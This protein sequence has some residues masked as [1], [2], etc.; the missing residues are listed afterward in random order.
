[1]AENINQTSLNSVSRAALVDGEWVNDFFGN[2]LAF[3]HTTEE[4]NKKANTTLPEPSD[5]EIYAQPEV[6]EEPEEQDPQEPQDP[7]PEEQDPSN[8]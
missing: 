8:P 6:V 7:D 5:F 1:M 4:V 3:A 2:D